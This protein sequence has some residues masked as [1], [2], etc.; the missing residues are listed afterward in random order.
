M[1]R[2]KKGVIKKARHKKILKLAKGYRGRAKNCYRVAIQKVEKALQ[3]AYR[4]RR[5]KKRDLRG[6]WIQR[7]NA[8]VREHSMIYSKFMNGLKLAQIDIDRKV[9]ADLAISQPEAFK[10]IVLKAKKA[11]ES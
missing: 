6:L 10:E 8:A 1:S 9:L 3:Y 11:L 4:D 7:I 5:N 2:V